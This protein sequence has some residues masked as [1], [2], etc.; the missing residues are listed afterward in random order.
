MEEKTA[1]SLEEVIR[2]KKKHLEKQLGKRTV[3]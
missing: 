3:G 1:S 2:G